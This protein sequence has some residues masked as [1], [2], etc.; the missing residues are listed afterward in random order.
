MSV[1]IKEKDRAINACVKIL[2]KCAAG[3]A[4]VKLSEQIK[5]EDIDFMLEMGYIEQNESF[6]QVTFKGRNLFVGNE[7]E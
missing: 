2:N 1:D 3:W 4:T 5:Q 7:T 6:Y